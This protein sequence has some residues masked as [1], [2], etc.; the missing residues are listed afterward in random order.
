MMIVIASDHHLSLIIM[1]SSLPLGADDYNK[2]KIDL[3]MNIQ[4]PCDL[5]SSIGLIMLQ[6]DDSDCDT[7]YSYCDEQSRH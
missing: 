4:V 2:L 7:C 5:Y 3:E 1:M 6:C